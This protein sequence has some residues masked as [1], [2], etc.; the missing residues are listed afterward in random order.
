MATPTDFTYALLVGVGWPLYEYLVDWPSFQRALRN[1][2]RR[3]RLREYRSTIF[4]QWL[5]VAIGIT[6]WLRADRPWSALALLAPRGPRLWISAGVLVLL[7]AGYVSQVVKAARHEQSRARLRKA[8]ASV[9]GI[10]PRSGAHYAWFL[11]TAVTAGLCEE[12]YFRGYL[13]WT[14]APAAGWW[15]AAAASA[16]AFGLLHAY[17]G[18]KGIVRTGVIGAVMTLVVVSTRS[19]LPAMALHALVDIGGGSVAWIAVRTKSPPTR[20]HPDV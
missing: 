6:L 2:P 13:I 12:F 5:I 17:Q 9:E 20:S 7:A 16:V 18:R 11:G 14:L 4:R 1:N 10:L 8:L 15:G 3:A 19:L